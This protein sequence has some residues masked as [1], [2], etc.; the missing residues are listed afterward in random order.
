[1]RGSLKGNQIKQ[2]FSCWQKTATEADKQIS[3]GRQFQNFYATAEKAFSQAA[4][5]CVS[6]ARKNEQDFQRWLNRFLKELM[7]LCV[8][9]NL[10]KTLK[11]N[12]SILN[13]IY[14]RNES[15]AILDG[16]R[17]K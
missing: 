14:L 8:G 7:D 13:C 5:H 15:G 10:H 12:A 1:M 3:L 2:V 16:S 6:K 17:L 11:V 4:S 9:L